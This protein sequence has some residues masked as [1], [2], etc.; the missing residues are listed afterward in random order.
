MRRWLLDK[1]DAIT[2]PAFP[3]EKDATLQCTR[4]GQV[5]EDFKGKSVFDLNALREKQLEAVRTKFQAD[6]NRDDLLKEVRAPD[7]AAAVAQAD[8]SD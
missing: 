1:N 8:Q 3:I 7:R 2:E 4:S 5:L 6:H